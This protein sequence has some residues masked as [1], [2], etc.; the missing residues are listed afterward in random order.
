MG[1][2]GGLRLQLVY[3]WCARRNRDLG[4]RRVETS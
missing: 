3:F 1:E 4:W 2:E